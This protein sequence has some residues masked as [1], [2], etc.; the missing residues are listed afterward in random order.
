[1]TSLIKCNQMVTG[2][3]ECVEYMFESLSLKEDHLKED[4]KFRGVCVI[5]S[6]S[7]IV[8]LLRVY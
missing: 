4:I 2:A 8:G 1:M 3:E 6:I 7:I 5:T